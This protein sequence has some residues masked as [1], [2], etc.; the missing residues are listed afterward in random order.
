MVTT[1][2]GQYIYTCGLYSMKYFY[3]KSK[4]KHITDAQRGGYG[5]IL[6][7]LHDNDMISN[8]GEP[9]L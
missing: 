6:H 4:I 1:V 2:Y 3:R 5:V 8:G 9:K 7:S